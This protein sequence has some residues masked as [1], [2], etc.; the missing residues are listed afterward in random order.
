M[1]GR[2]QRAASLLSVAGAVHGRSF[3]LHCVT[4]ATRARA[5][6]EFT[7]IMPNKSGS[8]QSH[9]S[10]HKAGG[11]TG[12]Q[13]GVW[14]S[15]GGKVVAQGPG[16]PNGSKVT[17]HVCKGGGPAGAQPG[18]WVSTGGKIVAQ[19]PGVPNGSQVTGHV[20]KADGGTGKK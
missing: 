9:G 19:G 10:G 1:V 3:Y 16:V 6:S 11:P 4:R 15:T 13:P 2:V 8:S 18:V 14:V 5:L 12:G 7:F 20:C 17:G